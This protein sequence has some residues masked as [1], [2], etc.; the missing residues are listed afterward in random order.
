MSSQTIP[1][2]LQSPPFVEIDWT[3]VG[4]RFR[5]GLR[6]SS[7]PLQEQALILGDILKDV[8]AEFREVL[9]QLQPDNAELM[10]LYGNYIRARAALAVRGKTIQA[11]KCQSDGGF[12][13]FFTDGSACHVAPAIEG[14]EVFAPVT[15]KAI[16]D[17]VDEGVPPE[18]PLRF[19]KQPSLAE[20]G[21]A[22]E[23]RAQNELRAALG[24]AQPDLALLAAAMS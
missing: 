22:G 19:L 7:R 20:R 10:Q 12:T 13:L 1:F 16:G 5:G 15:M 23:V 3:H 8:E 24:I 9:S 18:G 21:R 4:A 11:A 14:V 6:L 2:L 17:L